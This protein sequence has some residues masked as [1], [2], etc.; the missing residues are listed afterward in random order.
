MYWSLF[1]FLN[2]SKLGPG[3]IVG[4]EV[5]ADGVTRAAKLLVKSTDAAR[6][7]ACML[8]IFVYTAVNTGL[9]GREKVQMKGKRTR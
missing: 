5:T 2:S 7:F 3:V 4:S 9:R 6:A 1:C 8:D